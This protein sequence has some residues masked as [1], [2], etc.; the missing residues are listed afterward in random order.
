MVTKMGKLTEAILRNIYDERE[1]QEE[2]FGPQEHTMEEW[3]TILGE[4]VGE[5]ANAILED[6][7][8]EIMQEA[9]QVAAV[10]VA[11]IEDMDDH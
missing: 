1:R 4:E 6:G 3:F 5:V 2:I 9:I 7:P 10:C 8:F 11:M